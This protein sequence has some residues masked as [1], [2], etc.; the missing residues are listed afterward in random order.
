MC[1]EEAMRILETM[2][3][4]KCRL[5]IKTLTILTDGM[6]RVGTLNEARDLVN[7]LFA[8]GMMPDAGTYAGRSY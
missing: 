7:T 2:T 5:N 4:Q 3:F 6:F 8:E 1:M